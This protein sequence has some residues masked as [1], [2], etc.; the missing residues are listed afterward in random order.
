METIKRKIRR[1]IAFLLA[2][3]LVLTACNGQKQQ[4]TQ[5]RETND[6]NVVEQVTQ[7]EDSFTSLAEFD[8][9]ETVYVKAG[10]DGKAESISVEAVLKAGTQDGI[11]DQSNLTAIKNKEGDEEY[12]KQSDGSILWENRGS[13]IR[14]EGDSNEPL[15]VQVDIT[16]ELDGK[17]VSPDELAGKSGHLVMQFHY[18]NQ[19]TMLIEENGKEYQVAVPFMAMTLCML[20]DKVFS[21]LKIENGKLLTMGDERIAVGYAFPGLAESLQPEKVEFLEDLDI[22][23]FV[24]ISAQVKDFSMEFTA[25][26]IQNGMFQELDL[27]DL[28]DIDDLVDGMKDLK[29]A[30]GELV[31][32]TRELYRG[33]D[34]FGDYLQAYVDTMV[35]LKE[36]T[37]GIEQGVYLLSK[38]KKS[39]QDGADGLRDGLAVLNAKLS[40]GQVSGGDLSAEAG[41]DAENGEN[42]AE[43]LLQLIASMEAQA[44]V[45]KNS[46]SDGDTQGQAALATLEANIQTLKESLSDGDLS[47]FAGYE[48][49][50][51]QL[52]QG[53][54]ALASGVKQFNAGVDELYKGA[55]KLNDATGQVK[56]AGKELSEGYQE[57]KDGTGKLRDG[58]KEFDEEGIS[59]VTKQ[60]GPELKELA[61][62]IRA[63]K[64]ADAAYINYGGIAP[65]Q[66]GSVRFII[67]THE[68]KK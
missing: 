61:D 28:Q 1:K 46:V 27:E 2:V 36:G 31:D 12:T 4:E 25:T 56:D 49:M 59:E 43:A 14:Y 24:E 26:V 40:G 22:P 21:D 62:R 20:P 68:I 67:E 9:E 64:Q 23:D 29:K 53:S 54:V 41:T 51:A 32:G 33:A 60:A 52:A 44:A 55:Q 66:T 57:L 35:L 34:D 48:A 19:E 10:A 30:S 65:G 47:A 50:V 39:L 18:K 63:L 7:Q 16:Y 13:D 38:N 15:P 5:D 42:S 6:L 11:K 37:A 8:K 58:V 3:L 17:K 45:L